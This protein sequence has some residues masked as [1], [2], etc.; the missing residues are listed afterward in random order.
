MSK[1]NKVLSDFNAKFR[2]STAPKPVLKYTGNSMI[3]IVTNH[4][5]NAQPVFSVQAAKDSVR[6]K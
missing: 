6:V 1:E 5:S 2:G 4:K 3:G